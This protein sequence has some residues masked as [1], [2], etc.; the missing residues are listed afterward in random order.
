ME[1]TSTESDFRD[2]SQLSKRP[3]FTKQKFGDY[4]Q[5]ETARSE[6]IQ[7]QSTGFQLAGTDA[8]Y[9]KGGGDELSLSSSSTAHLH[10]LQRNCL[11]VFDDLFANSASKVGFHDQKGGRI[12]HK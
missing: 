5:Q 6:N 9:L 8:S 11:L 4:F 10:P 2:E 1:A 7:A 3:T 12:L